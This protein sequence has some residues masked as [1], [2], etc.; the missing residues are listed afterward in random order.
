MHKEKNIISKTWIFN[1]K[2]AKKFD[3]HVKQSV[4]FYSVFQ[5]H[6]AKISEFFL[7]N[8]A[9]I[10]DLGCSTG[11]T[12]EEIFKLKLNTKF[13][14]IGVD[15]NKL[16]IKSAK[17]KLKKYKKNNVNLEVSNLNNFK[18]K[19]CNL[20]ISILI[21][22]FLNLSSRNK[23]LKQIY[24][25][26]EI[27]GA[28]ITVEKIK[29][30]HGIFEDMLNQLYYDFKLKQKISAKNIILKTKSLR[31]GMNVYDQEQTINFLK[32]NNFKKIDIFFKMYNFVGII[33]FK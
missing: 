30:K 16:M 20:V 8:D 10:Y 12:I 18:L 3:L 1:D 2:V 26:L 23:L 33:A 31:S 29:S 5:K 11:K 32:Q 28:L 15:Q 25:K 19:K 13:K 6:I 4:P 27:G 9:L 17:Q 22:P 24:D 14:I 7:K 21:F